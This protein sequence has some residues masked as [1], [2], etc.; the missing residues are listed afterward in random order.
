MAQQKLQIANKN[1]LIE[2]FEKFKY[3]NRKYLIYTNVSDIT[4]GFLIY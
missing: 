1:D 4:L 3:S 2:N